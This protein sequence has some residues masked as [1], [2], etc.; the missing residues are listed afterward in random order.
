MKIS[1]VLTNSLFAGLTILHLSIAGIA[2]AD[3]NAGH[4]KAYVPMMDAKF[5]TMSAKYGMGVTP[6]NL[7]FLAFQ[8]FFASEGIPS[9]AGLEQAYRN[10]TVKPETLVK[11]AIAMNRLPASSIDDKTYLDRV[12]SQLDDLTRNN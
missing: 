3:P 8:G 2:Q 4:G 6:F 9:A 12:K 1:K 11:A 5:P 7:V 10:G